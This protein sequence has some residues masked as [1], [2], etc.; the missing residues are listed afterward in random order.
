MSFVIEIEVK[1]KTCDCGVIYYV[2]S[3]VHYQASCPMCAHRKIEVQIRE[4]HKLDRK[5]SSLKGVITRLKRKG[6]K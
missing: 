1:A 3:W 5:I 2:P 4:I 6:K